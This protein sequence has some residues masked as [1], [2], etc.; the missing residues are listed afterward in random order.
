[1]SSSSAPSGANPRTA[2]TARPVAPARAPVTPA[3]RDRRECSGGPAIAPSRRGVERAA[4][5]PERHPTCDEPRELRAVELG[6][7]RVPCVEPGLSAGVEPIAALV[8]RR[9]AQ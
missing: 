3:L 1:M 7:P 4:L 6:G 2:T 8:E 9:K 5:E